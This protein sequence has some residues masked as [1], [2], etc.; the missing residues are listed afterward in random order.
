[1]AGEAAKVEDEMLKRL[2]T[3]AMYP[4]MERETEELSD[5]N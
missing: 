3:F 1:M 4:G 5:V 2:R